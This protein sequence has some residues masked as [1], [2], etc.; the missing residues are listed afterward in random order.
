MGTF[1][2]RLSAPASCNIT[3]YHDPDDPCSWVVRKWKKGLFG[4]RLELSK[5]FNTKEQ[6]ERYARLLIEQCDAKT[7]VQ[8]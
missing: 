4:K 8:S 6:A 2:T 5:W 3:L 7:R 1:E